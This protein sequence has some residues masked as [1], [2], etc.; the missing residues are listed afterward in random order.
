MVEHPIYDAIT[1]DGGFVDFKMTPFLMSNPPTAI[2]KARAG[3]LE[4]V[5]GR[6]GASHEGAA[7]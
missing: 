1:K 7:I 2:E 4:S 3:E 5:F 6:H